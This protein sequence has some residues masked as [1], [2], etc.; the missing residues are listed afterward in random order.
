MG[1][2]PF[3]RKDENDFIIVAK[4]FYFPQLQLI[5][6][7]MWCATVLLCYRNRQSLLE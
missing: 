2:S 5:F 6:I 3:C 4:T 7:V 1:M